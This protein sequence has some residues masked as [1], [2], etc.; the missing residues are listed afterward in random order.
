MRNHSYHS[1]SVYVRV[2]HVANLL[3][4]TYSHLSAVVWSSEGAGC[5]RT[6]HVTFRC[7]HLQMSSRGWLSVMGLG[8]V[9][10]TF[11]IWNSAPD[12]SRSAEEMKKCSHYTVAL[13]FGVEST[14]CNGLLDKHTYFSLSFIR[15]NIGLGR[16]GNSAEDRNKFRV[17]CDEIGQKTK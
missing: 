15:L 3:L 8:N 6:L 14:S 11:G 4:M 17:Y 1:P 7:H 9:C 13:I 10:V 2:I 5:Y 16:G 12:L